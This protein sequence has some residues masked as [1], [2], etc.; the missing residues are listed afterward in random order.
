MVGKEHTDCI[1]GGGSCDVHPLDVVFGFLLD[2][3][4]AL[5]DICDVIETSLLN[6]ER[7][8][9]PVEVHHTVHRLA[10]Q[11]QELLGQETE[12]RVVPRLL[13]VGWRLGS[14]RR[15]QYVFILTSTHT[16]VPSQAFY[17]ITSYTL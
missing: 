16:R 15:T 1:S 9:G 4:H 17:Y 11:L 5:Q 6:A 3:V 10:E 2:K 13:L 8:G 7:L 14:C 12:G